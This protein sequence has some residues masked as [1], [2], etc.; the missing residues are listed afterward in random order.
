MFS[1]LITPFVAV[2]LFFTAF[3]VAMPWHAPASSVIVTP[4]RASTAVTGSQTGISAPS[5]GDPKGTCTASDVTHCC[6]QTQA[7]GVPLSESRKPCLTLKCISP[8]QSLQV[9][10][11][12]YPTFWGLSELDVLPLPTL[13]LPARANL[14]AANR[15]QA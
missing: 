4:T 3:A 9:G 15:E 12:T 6:E 8:T 7:V 5:A 14:S 13:H 1:R 10:S 11:L 2:F